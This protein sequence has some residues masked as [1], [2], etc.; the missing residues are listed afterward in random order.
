[1]APIQNAVK[2]GRKVDRWRRLK[3]GPLAGLGASTR[4]GGRRGA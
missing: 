1:V 4:P 3:S 2:A